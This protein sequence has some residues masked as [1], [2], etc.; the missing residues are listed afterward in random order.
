M[1]VLDDLVAGALQDS[2][3][4]EKIVSIDELRTNAKT[5]TPAKDALQWLRSDTGIPVIA[6]IKRASPSKGH[7]SDITDPAK[8]AQEYEL[9][10]A[11]AISVLTEERVFKGSL[12][13]LDDVRKAVSI[14]VLRKDFIVTDYQIFEARAHGADLILLIVAALSD[15]QLGSLLKT[16]HELGMRALVETHTPQEV[17][18]AVNAGAKIIGVNARNLKNLHVD[19]SKYQELADLIPEDVVKVAESGIFGS[20]E[21][22]QYARA[23][24]DAVLVGEAVATAQNHELAVSRLVQAGNK[25]RESEQLPL[26]THQ[27]PYFGCFGG[28]HVPEAL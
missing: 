18:R 1:S 16:T 19:V 17:Q 20:V 26:S 28:R 21:I 5:Q 11:S 9:G 14:P 12:Q 7:L 15:E 8:L 2:Q 4:R 25:V 10:G 3:N 27:G 13:D 22:E 6:E 24:A 23:G